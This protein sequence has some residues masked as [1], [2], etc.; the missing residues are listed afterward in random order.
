M[1]ALRLGRSA[2]GVLALCV[3]LGGCGTDEV[4]VGPP[5]DPPPEGA[6]VPLADLLSRPRAELAAQCDHWTDYVQNREKA[7]RDGTLVY[8]LLPRVRLPLVVPVWREAKFSPRAGFSL[9]PYLAEDAKDNDLALHL[10]RFGDIE[11]ALRLAEPHDE[12]V[13]RQIEACRGE[14]NYPLEW[15]RLAALRLQV[16]ESR[17]ASGDPEGRADLAGLHRQLRELLDAKAARGSLGAALLARGHRTLTLAAAA[18]RD[19]HKNELA[20]LADADLAAW[21]ELPPPLVNVPFAA[22]RSA[23][24]ALLQSPGQGHVIPALTTARALDV[25]D[26]PVPADG[27]QAV[28]GCFDAADRLAQV[29]V[30]YR[31]R[32]ADYYLDP[33]QLGLR[34]DEHGLRGL[35]AK[36]VAGVTARTY[37]LAGAACEV[38]VVAR[39]STVGAFVNLTPRPP[40]ASVPA[41]PRDFGL[42]SLDR[43]FEQDRRRLAPEQLGDVLQTGQAKVLECLKTPLEP[44]RPT[45]AVLRREPGH[46]LVAGF[47]LLYSG[48]AL[49]PLCQIALPLWAAW[50]PSRLGGVEDGQGGHLA[51]AWQD[52]HTRYVLKLPHLVG[53]ALALEAT[54]TTGPAGLARRAAAVAAADRAERLARLKAGRPVARL[55]R[56]L[57]VGWATPPA[58]V[59][60]GM[61]RAEVL[62]ALPKGQSVLKQDYPGLLSVLFT[63]EPPKSAARVTRQLLI[64][65]D[66][67]GRVAEV[68]ARYQDGP[69][70]A[71]TGRWSHELL[72]GLIRQCGAAVESPGPWAAAWADLPRKPAPVQARWQDDAT[73]LTC[74]RDGG[75]AEVVLRDCPPDH[76]AGAPLPPLAYLP[77]GPQGCSLDEAREELF[78]AWHVQEPAQVAGGAFALTPPRGSPYDLVLV[79]FDKDRVSRIIGRHPASVP[80]ASRASQLADQLTAAWGR[81]LR[82]LGWPSRQ[83]ADAERVL[84][85]LGWNDDRTRVRLFWQETE[86]GPRLFTEWKEL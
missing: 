46:D 59:Q 72:A 77:R 27:A 47:T 84:Q 55:P 80:P 62:A 41:L 40:D 5:A 30:L 68:R 31:P 17:L 25:F 58:Y 7:H 43:S 50:G 19:E 56:R 13:R 70:A 52:A 54:D 63:G 74:Q 37:P 44:R 36:A 14:R 49:P 82:T 48:D 57:E 76:E 10:A 22:P 45:E 33:S 42:V 11:A 53:E 75:G 66:E 51:L 32:L 26:L 61:T 21:G 8:G 86:D 6:D 38:A 23:V 67:S 83:D 35:D 15:T 64:R 85:A 39:G 71:G 79:W 81:D 12:G 4:T 16:A 9:P 60:L 69:A 78:R 1:S 2:I 65:F 3:A 18:W 28:L 34:L 24:A 73:L 29:L 20:D